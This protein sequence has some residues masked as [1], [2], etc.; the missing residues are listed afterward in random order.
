[1]GLGASGA[2]R[3][4]HGHQDFAFTGGG[5]SREVLVSHGTQQVLVLGDA[6]LP[7]QA[8]DAVGHVKTAGDA[9]RQCGRDQQT[10]FTRPVTGAE[11]YRCR[12]HLAAGAIWVR[13]R[14]RG[15][16]GG[17]GIC[18][19][20]AGGFGESCRRS[21]WP[22][23]RGVVDALNQNGSSLCQAGRGCRGAT[24]VRD[25]DAERAIA[26]GQ[27]V[28]AIEENH[29]LQH[30]AVHVER[31]RARNGQVAIVGVNRFGKA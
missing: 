13:Q 16:Q 17:P 18:F 20:Q 10:V 8:E 25:A 1:M 5:C 30:L 7:R 23:L 21:F 28:T 2:Q 27:I 4:G 22:H 29:F 26:R 19:G 15:R 31:G 9:D 6:A 11:A 12:G 14:E 3:I 24:V